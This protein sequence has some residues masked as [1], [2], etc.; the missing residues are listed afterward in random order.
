MFCCNQ[1]LLFAVVPS[2]G[3]HG[4]VCHI[5]PLVD[6]HI[7]VGGC[8]NRECGGRKVVQ[9]KGAA[10][11]DVPIVGISVIVMGKTTL[12]VGDGDLLVGHYDIAPD[13]YKPA[14]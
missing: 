1:S 11:N 2:I 3:N 13:P 7:L 10:H 8:S 6:M 9:G 14:S 4:G 5:G 12:F